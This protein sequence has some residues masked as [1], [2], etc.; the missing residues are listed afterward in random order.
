MLSLDQKVA[1]DILK[2]VGGDSFT[3]ILFFFNKTW[4][5]CKLA[6]VSTFKISLIDPEID[7]FDGD[8]S[9]FGVI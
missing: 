3:V 5:H 9:H 8:I 1:P 4:Q 6:T 2:T 7:A